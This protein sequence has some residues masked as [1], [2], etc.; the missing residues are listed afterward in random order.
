MDED[1]F[2]DYY[3][4]LEVEYGASID[5]I[6]ANFR[7]LAKKYHPDVVQ[8]S[9]GNVDFKIILEAYK[10][11]TDEKLRE[12]YNRKYLTKKSQT[13]SKKVDTIK[14]IIDPSRIEYKLSLLNISKAG[15]DLSKGFSRREF[16]EELGEDLVVYLTDKE[17]EEGAILN[18]QL[19]ARSVCN[20]CYGGNRNCYRCDGTG[21]IT[22]LEDVRIIIPP[23]VK[24]SEVIFVD[25]KKI[26]R[27]KGITKFSP[28]DLR[29][30]VMWLS[31]MDVK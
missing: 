29:I 2:K 25:L 15:F 7:K 4:I 10:V 6:K 12:S 8:D 22:T 3:Q 9:D 24:H 19:P 17:V 5:K 18:I 26:N 21:Y 31:V 27:K 28:N 11:L 1:N 30:K 14:N 13:V 16:L 20:V 23:G